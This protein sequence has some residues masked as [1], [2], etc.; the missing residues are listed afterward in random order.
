MCYWFDVVVV[1]VVCVCVCMCGCC[2]CCFWG[3]CVPKLWVKFELWFE[4]NKTCGTM[5]CG[6]NNLEID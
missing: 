1:V 2:C 6:M 3:A 4:K 5:T